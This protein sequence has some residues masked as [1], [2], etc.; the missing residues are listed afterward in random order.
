M[1]FVKVIW[2]KIAEYF[3]RR[4]LI[5]CFPISQSLQYNQMRF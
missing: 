5:K 3:E 2:F 4:I 1:K